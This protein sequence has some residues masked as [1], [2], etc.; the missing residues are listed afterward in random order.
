MKFSQLLLLSLPILCLCASVKKAESQTIKLND[1][2]SF[3]IN[4][5]SVSDALEALSR[6][7]GT[8]F[9]YNPDQL[10]SARNVKID[11]HDRSLIEVLNAILGPAKFGYR[12]MGNQVIIYQNKPDVEEALDSETKDSRQEQELPKEQKLQEKNILQNPDTV[13]L[14]KEVHDTIRLTDVVL[15]TDTVFQKIPTSVS[16]GEIFRVILAKEMTADYKWDVGITAGYFIPNAVY[17]ATGSYSEK[18]TQYRES[19]S[20]NSFSGTAGLDVRLSKKKW[21]AATG[22]HLTLFGQKLDYSYLQQEGGFFSKDTLDPYYTL[23]E[24]DTTWY[25]IVDSTYVPIDN[26]LYNYKINNHHRYLEIPLVIQRNWGY[27]S[28]LIFVR[29]GIIPGFFLGSSGQQILAEENGITSLKELKHKSMVLSYTAGV[30]AA[31]PLGRKTI[32]STT[33]YFRNQFRSIYEDFPIE[34][35]FSGVG[36]SAGLTYKLY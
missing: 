20:N 27:R 24:G 22:I 19:Y 12:L 31:F 8:T 28:M 30:G 3:S 13:F 10:N 9:S 35:K 4:N 14:V 1:K 17:S 23:I 26:K 5:V 34:T 25:Y 18:L 21:T 33:L 32:L 2:I 6:V 36:I 16:S 15:K 29:G 11:M 7:T